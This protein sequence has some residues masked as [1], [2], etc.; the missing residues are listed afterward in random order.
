MSGK[1]GGGAFY[2]GVLDTVKT[3]GS[4][5]AHTGSILDERTNLEVE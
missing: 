4:T 3:Q 2:C 5:E 1:W